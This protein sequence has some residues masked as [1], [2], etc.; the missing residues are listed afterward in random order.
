MAPTHL[1]P[2][3]QAAEAPGTLPR[4]PGCCPGPVR[5]L[6]PS[7]PC[8][9][10]SLQHRCLWSHQ[11]RRSDP[12]W[13]CGSDFEVFLYLSFLVSVL[14]INSVLTTHSFQVARLRA[15]ERRGC[16]LCPSGQ[17]G[18]RPPWRSL[19]PLTLPPPP[20]G[21]LLALAGELGSRLLLHRFLWAPFLSSACV[22]GDAMTDQASQERGPCFHPR[23]TSHSTGPR[24]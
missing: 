21:A 10:Q 18:H 20:G 4:P 16:N 13:F 3:P 5:A 11:A 2:C 6:P 8:S 7:S 17:S 15:G 19:G 1:G 24:V 22:A 23:P 14:H 9:F 12:S